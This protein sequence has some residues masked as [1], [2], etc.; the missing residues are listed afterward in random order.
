MKNIKN[1]RNEIAK[2]EL[3]QKKLKYQRKT[4]IPSKTRTMTSWEAYCK[5]K[6]NRYDLRHLYIIYGELRGKSI[7]IVEPN[8]K[9]EPDEY[10]L[11]QIRKK[12]KS[13]SS[14]CPVL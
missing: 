12:Y 14:T 4:E 6:N 1:L 7:Y 9:T 3:E 5:H 13:N 10:E 2:L 11:E 8:R